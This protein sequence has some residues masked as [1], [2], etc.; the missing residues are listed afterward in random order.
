MTPTSVDVLL[1]LTLSVALVH[2]L[3]GVD[4][5]LPFV[6]LGRTQRW[7]LR[8][9]LAITAV[10]GFGHVLGSVLLGAVGVAVGAALGELEWLE[11]TRGNVAAWL[12]IGLGLAY[13]AWAAWRTLRGRRHVHVHAHGDGTVHAHQHDHHG[14]HAHPHGNPS[15]LLAFWSLFVVF[16]LGPCEPLIPLLMAPAAEHR[17]AVVAAVA[18]V[19]GVATVGTMVVIVALGYAGMRLPVFRRLERWGHSLAGLAIAASGLAIQ[20]VGI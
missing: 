6:V 13:A 12:L 10:C 9:V 2:T 3:I 5:F 4:H 17:W 18:I 8:K 16:V 11:A 19:F 15:G 1:G 7:P 20:V 14:E